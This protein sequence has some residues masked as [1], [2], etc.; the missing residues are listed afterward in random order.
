[1]LGCC[2]LAQGPACWPAVGQ[3]TIV[4][5][6]QRNTFAEP[7][8]WL[9]SYHYGYQYNLNMVENVFSVAILLWGPQ[10]AETQDSESRRVGL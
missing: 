3:L 7:A 6:R 2:A 5:C 4:S 9:V 8:G 1:M 10:P